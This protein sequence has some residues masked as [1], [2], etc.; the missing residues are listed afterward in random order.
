MAASIVALW[1]SLA[2]ALAL[3]PG[4]VAFASDVRSCCRVAAGT[5]VAVELVN[6]V[7]TKTAHSG[8]T[9][10][11]RLTAPLIVNGEV[12][13]RAGAQ[14]VGEVV[15]S[16]KPGMGGK[17]GKLVLAARY[18]GPRGVRVPL[19]GLQLAAGGHN[20]T[21]AAQVVGLS[22][23]AFGPLG[24]IGLAVPGGNVAFAPGT[25]GT[26]KVAAD[27]ELRPLGRASREMLVAARRLAESEAFASTASGAI[28]IAPPPAGEG[29]VIFFRR[30]SVLGIGQWFNVRENGHALGKLKNGTYFVDITDPGPHTYTATM[31][32]ELKDHLKLEVAAGETYFVEGALTKGVVVGAADLSP[33]DRSAFDNVSLKLKFARPA[34][35]EAST[36]SG[37]RGTSTTGATNERAPDGNDAAGR[38]DT[39]RPALS[40]DGRQ[41]VPP[42]QASASSQN[43]NGDIRP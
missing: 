35:G 14:G 5:T 3:A 25:K 38:V 37:G 10:A 4:P 19:E 15:E 39:R 43:A 33:S 24:L 6:R 40:A 28:D 34:T 9:F 11:L 30:K 26:A 20:N 2:M 13:L 31:E 42:P 7:S 17:G 12:V 22:G 27:V 18:L 23:I 16:A 21:T 41:P 36:A 8:D 29:Q 32:P 1:T